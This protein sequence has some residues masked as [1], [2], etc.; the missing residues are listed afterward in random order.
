MNTWFINGRY[1]LAGWHATISFPCARDHEREIRFNIIKSLIELDKKVAD[2]SGRDTFLSLALVP[3]IRK[4]PL[5]T[6]SPFQTDES[7]SCT[8]HDQEQHLTSQACE[9]TS[10]GTPSK[11]D[12]LEH[13]SISIGECSLQV[14]ASFI[15]TIKGTRLHVRECTQGAQRFPSEPERRQRLKHMRLPAPDY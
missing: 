13:T 1:S 2:F 11:T 7:W 3:F 8:P 5:Y 14:P 6:A 9:Q 15:F 12:Y 4:P 10:T